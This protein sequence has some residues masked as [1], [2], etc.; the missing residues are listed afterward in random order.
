MMTRFP[1]VV[2]KKHNDN[3]VSLKI[4]GEEWAPRATAASVSC[5][6]EFATEVSI[7][8]M[9]R[10]VEIIDNYIWMEGDGEE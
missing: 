3:I 7:T 10:R 2:I 6:N 8:F 1:E 9:C 5:H 4:D